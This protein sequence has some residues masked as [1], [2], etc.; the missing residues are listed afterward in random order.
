MAMD[1]VPKMESVEME[2]VTWR[3]ETAR[4]TEGIGVFQEARA[5]I[6]SISTSNDAAG[7]IPAPQQICLLQD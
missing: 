3:D 5:G 2:S 6:F 1:G 7:S 4:V